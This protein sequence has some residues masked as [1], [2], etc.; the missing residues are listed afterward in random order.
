MRLCFFNIYYIYVIYLFMFPYSWKGP[1]RKHDQP[2][3]NHMTGLL[4]LAPCKA[5]HYHDIDSSHPLQGAQGYYNSS[6]NLPSNFG[7]LLVEIS[8]LFHETGKAYAACSKFLE[9]PWV[10]CKAPKKIALFQKLSPPNH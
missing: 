4:L 6:V 5:P 3:C 10:P 8:H 1:Y 9:S 7:Q 2:G